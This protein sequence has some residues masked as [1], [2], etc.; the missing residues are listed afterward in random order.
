MSWY[1]KQQCVYYLYLL[2]G[3]IMIIMAQNMEVSL[4]LPKEFASYVTGPT[5]Y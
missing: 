1:I 4:S 2:R 5:S 3:I